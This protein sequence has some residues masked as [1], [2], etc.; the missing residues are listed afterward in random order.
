M[1]QK[2]LIDNDALLKLARYGLLNEAIALFGCSKADVHV[3]ATA[4]YVLL[5]A[6]NCLRFCK[7]AESTLRLENFL[8]TVKP[9]VVEPPE[10]ELLDRLNAV[11]NIDPGEALLLAVGATNRDMLLITGDKRALAALC[12]YNT[13]APVAN[14]L[15]GRVVVMEVLFLMFVEH[16]F[17]YIQECVRSKPDVDTA[18]TIAFGVSIAADYDLVRGGLSSY[19][20]HLQT[21]TR[22]L[23]YLPSTNF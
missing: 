7:D 5:P 15:A 22:D 13:V 21:I 6:Q 18:L 10:L 2:I 14:A 23:L 9:I 8:R 11:Q 1:G 3:L 20:Q 16:Q 17:L 4:K 12:S 19:I